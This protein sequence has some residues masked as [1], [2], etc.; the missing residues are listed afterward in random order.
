MELGSHAGEGNKKILAMVEHSSQAGDGPNKIL[1]MM[2]ISYHFLGRG[3]D[4]DDSK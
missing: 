1:A 3:A 2:E 4:N